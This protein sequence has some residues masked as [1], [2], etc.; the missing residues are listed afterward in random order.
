MR[1]EIFQIALMAIVGFT[2]AAPV[3]TSQEAVEKRLLP[4]YPYPATDRI[5]TTPNGKRA[6]PPPYEELYRSIAKTE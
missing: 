5:P 4:A 1:F 2:T 6:I 3:G